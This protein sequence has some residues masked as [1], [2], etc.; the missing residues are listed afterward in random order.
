MECSIEEC[1]KPA[2]TR[3]WCPMHYERWRRNGDPLIA[4]R[5]ASSPDEALELR[6]ERRGECLVW[7]GARNDEGYGHVWVDGRAVNVHRYAYER[8]HGKLPADIDVDH[9]C[10]N[11]A[12]F[13]LKH[14][15][16]ATRAQNASHR[17]GASKSNRSTGV[18]NVL[19]RKN[20]FQVQVRHQGRAY[21]H[22]HVTIEAAEAEA[23]ALRERLHGDFA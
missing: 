3:T 18:R 19:R 11:P 13:E 6:G 1:A 2:R 16:P 10:H 9:R 8:E 21:G 23:I 14:L 5:Y 7:T 17:R 15:R 4:K 12:C 22:F 20:G